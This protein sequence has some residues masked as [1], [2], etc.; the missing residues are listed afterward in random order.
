MLRGFRPQQL[1]RSVNLRKCGCWVNPWATGNS[2]VG[3]HNRWV[4]AKAALA[5][6]VWSPMCPF[7]VPIRRSSYKNAT[8]TVFGDGPHHTYCSLLRACSFIRVE[9]ECG[10][11]YRLATLMEIG[12]NGWP[13]QSNCPN[14]K[15]ILP[16]NA[17]RFRRWCIPLLVVRMAP[18]FVW[19]AFILNPGKYGDTF[20]S[21]MLQSDFNAQPAT[22]ATVFCSRNSTHLCL[23]SI[24]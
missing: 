23:S 1:L 2:C 10:L 14:T 22:A 5:A 12:E 7:I 16:A 21:L 17:G 19:T 18:C 4:K 20:F 24:M 8:P 9:D 6:S 13:L 15:C 11:F 3:T